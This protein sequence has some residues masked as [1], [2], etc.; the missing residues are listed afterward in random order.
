M[1]ID[2][3][4][5]APQCFMV[6]IEDIDGQWFNDPKVFREEVAARKWAS[7]TKPPD[8]YSLLLYRCEF[9]EDLSE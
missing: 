4:V 1:D 2:I 9:V 6:T 5:E 8:G 3:K 7:M